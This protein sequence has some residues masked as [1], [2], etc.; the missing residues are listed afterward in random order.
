[1]E[2]SDNDYRV[3][4]GNLGKEATEEHLKRIFK[5]YSSIIKIKIVRDSRSK[6]TKGYGFVSFMNY[7]E[8]LDA[9]KTK[10]GNFVIY[11]TR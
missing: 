9:L 6:R 8:C 5:D 7:K 3:F 11:S 2:F 10:N 4:I 1:M